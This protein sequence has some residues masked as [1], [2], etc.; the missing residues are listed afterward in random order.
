LSE[1]RRNNQVTNQ[2]S[3]NI[4]TMQRRLHDAAFRTPAASQLEY[5]LGGHGTAYVV[6]AGGSFSSAYFVAQA[7][8][9][10][11]S[12]FAAPAYPYD[13]IRTAR[14]TDYIF[15]VSHSGNTA[16]ISAVCARAKEIGVGRTVLLTGAADP[17]AGRTLER[18]RD[19]VISYAYGD[20]PI[21]KGFVSIYGTVAP[22]AVIIATVARKGFQ[23]FLKQWPRVAFRA[24]SI[25]DQLARLT[26]DKEPLQILSGGFATP[27][28]IDLESKFTEANLGIV[29]CHEI[30]DFS[31]GRFMSLL[32]PDHAGA[33]SLL[34][35]VHHL[36]SYEKAVV[37]VLTRN[38]PLATYVSYFDEMLGALE[39]ITAAQFMS[40]RIGSFREIDI[41]KP[42]HISE[43]GLGLYQYKLR[44]G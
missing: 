19:A 17:E 27:A 22:C 38:G 39:L 6:G 44:E 30:K 43:E 2:S 7:I 33:P 5:I 24:S 28:M 11:S 9:R 3:E 21:E 14:G 41:S 34:L 18:D 26:P 15:V 12:I 20:F 4:A 8:N 32:S 36:T 35:A 13:Y 31:H 16:D 29:Q 37:E 23:R 40:E 1:S 42:Y 10:Y 25:G